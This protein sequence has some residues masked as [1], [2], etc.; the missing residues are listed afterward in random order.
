MDHHR[1]I[2]F[3]WPS[4]SLSESPF[5]SSSG[6]DLSL[7]TQVSSLIKPDF[8]CL[9]TVHARGGLP[10]IGVLAFTDLERGKEYVGLEDV[11]VMATRHGDWLYSLWSF[12]RIKGV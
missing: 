9:E 5:E 4:V 11:R 2:V 1:F 7:N 3:H 8:R 6:V 12:R 10:G